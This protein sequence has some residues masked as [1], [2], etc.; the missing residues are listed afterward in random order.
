VINGISA[1]SPAFLSSKNFFCIRL[2]LNPVVSFELKAHR[3]AI[4]WR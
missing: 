1:A 3:A 2:I 4:L